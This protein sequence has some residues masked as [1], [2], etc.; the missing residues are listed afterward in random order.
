MTRTTLKLSPPLQTSAYANKGKFCP[1]GM[2]LRAT[3][4]VHDESSVGLESGTFWP[5]SRDLTTRPPRPPKHS[6]PSV[7]VR[8]EHAVL[9][10]GNSLD[11]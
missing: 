2:I 4:P 9:R 7:Y 11:S 3:G 6:G 1:L 8:F 5:Q 10:S